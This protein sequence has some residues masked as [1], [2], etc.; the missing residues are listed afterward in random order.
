MAT[1]SAGVSAVQGPSTVYSGIREGHG[2]SCFGAL[3]GLSLDGELK[4]TFLQ[5]KV[6]KPSEIPKAPPP[7]FGSSEHHPQ[8]T[9]RP[10]RNRP[11]LQ[12]A[13]PVTQDIA[14]LQRRHIYRTGMRSLHVGSNRISRFRNFSPRMVREDEELQSRANMWIRRELRVFE[15][16]ADNSEFLIEYILAILK[17]IDIKSSTGAAEDMLTEFLGRENSR[18]FLHELHAFLRY[19]SFQLVVPEPCVLIIICRSPF[20]SV[21]AFDSFVQY[22]HPL[23]THFDSDGYALPNQPSRKRER[24]N[25]DPDESRTQQRRL[26]V[27]G[28]PNG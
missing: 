17:T 23:P 27:P 12:R 5:H 25:T 8:N 9:R 26:N 16:T 3:F 6:E 20:T 11:R 24:D 7:E 15:W 10:V 13:E 2:E 22:E 1:A 18:T 14:L 19:V 28:L 21:H 4:L